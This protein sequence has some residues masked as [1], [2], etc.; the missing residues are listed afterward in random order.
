MMLASICYFSG[1]VA[2]SRDAWVV[3]L[4]ELAPVIVEEVV[5]NYIN[6]NAL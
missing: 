2:P 6:S 1:A 3:R 4:S 5:V